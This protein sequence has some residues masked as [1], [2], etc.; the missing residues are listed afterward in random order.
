MT[1]HTRKLK[2]IVFELDG[3]AFE[4]QLQS[5]QIVDNT[6]DGDKIYSFGADGQNEDSEETNPDWS[7]ALSFWSD[8]RL[9]G[10]SDW[11]WA[12]KGRT[13]PFSI[14]HNVD[15][16]GE[17]VDFT[18]ECKIKAPPVGGAA[19]DTEKS[20]VTLPLTGEPDYD[21]AA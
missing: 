1:I 12:N 16:A 7:L 20:D 13:V 19:R 17:V 2:H 4:A 6:D 9:D 14:T 15:N 21:R 18:G 10:V 8:W 11:L 3:E 5:W